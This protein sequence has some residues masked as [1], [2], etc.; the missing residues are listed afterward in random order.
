MSLVSDFTDSEL[1]NIREMLTQR[2]KKDVEIELADC[3]LVLDKKS[4]EVTHCPTVFWHERGA[5]FVVFKVGLFQYR[6]QFFYTPHEQ[7]GTGIDQYND[8]D[9]CVAAALQTQADHERERQGVDS[10]SA[11]ESLKPD[12]TAK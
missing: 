1:H 6:T 12:E 10:G 7:Y 5:N 9:E 11:G 8:L 2:Y 3:E 4:E